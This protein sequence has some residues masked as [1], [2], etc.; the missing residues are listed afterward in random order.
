[1]HGEERKLELI[2]NGGSM[3]VGRKKKE[4]DERDE[5]GD[6]DGMVVVARFVGL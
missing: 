2:F 5:R 3:A 1:M 6:G 4:G